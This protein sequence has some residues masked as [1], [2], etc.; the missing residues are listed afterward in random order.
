MVNTRP[1][2]NLGVGEKHSF[3]VDRNADFSN[4]MDDEGGEDFFKCDL[5]KEGDRI[6]VAEKLGLTD[7]WKHRKGNHTSWNDDSRNGRV[8][9]DFFSMVASQTKTASKQWMQGPVELLHRILSSLHL[10]TLSRI[11]LA[12][13]LLVFGSIDVELFK[14]P[15]K[16]SGKDVSNAELKKR[17]YILLD[18]DQTKDGM[19]G[20]TFEITARFITDP[21]MSIATICKAAK[22]R[23]ESIYISKH[24]TQSR[25]PCAIVGDLVSDFI[26]SV[27]DK[28]IATNP[29][30]SMEDGVKCPKFSRPKLKGKN[31]ATKDL[32]ANDNDFNKAWGGTCPL[33]LDERWKNY[34][35]NPFEESAKAEAKELLS[36]DG[37]SPP[38]WLDLENITTQQG[39]LSGGWNADGMIR[40]SLFVLPPIVAIFHAGRNNRS[41]FEAGILSSQYRK[42]M[43]NY[44]ARF[45][46][47]FESIYPSSQKLHPAIKL[48]YNQEY[49]DQCMIHQQHILVG[50][51][52]FTIMAM[53]SCFAAAS[54]DK[55]EEMPVI[56]ANIKKRA[57]QLREAFTMMDEPVKS[58]TSVAITSTLQHLGTFLLR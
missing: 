22:L 1:I 34:V 39:S 40:N 52:V 29:D 20:G 19:V 26:V 28:S 17:L 14:F 46:F 54:Y 56:R 33:L 45:H 57:Q 43:T 55:S 31:S 5:R 7:E 11:D 12:T 35:N 32:E 38:F 10:H 2:G 8:L 51:V 13:A 23:S 21:S 6:K 9:Y 44:M 25:S 50:S 30:E 24:C 36:I 49:Q 41:A 4:F 42:D 3:V 18:P 47:G 15:M 48:Q 58:G 27:S 16:A 37:I 53:N